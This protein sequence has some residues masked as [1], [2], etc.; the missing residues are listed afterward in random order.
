MLP[1]NSASGVMVL[2]F[3]RDGHRD[4]LFACHSKNGNHRTDSFLYW[5]SSDGFSTQRR[6]LLPSR[7]AHLLMTVDAGN[8]YDR[9]NRYE[10]VSRPF[11]A[12]AGSQL[13]EISWR[14][15]TPF[16]T[17]LD[18]Q[19]RTAASQE[20][21]ANAPWTGPNGGD[22]AFTAPGSRLAETPP[23]HRW[24][25]YKAGLVS[26]DSVNTPVLRSVTI[27]YVVQP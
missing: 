7:G 23:D 19:V 4:I 10:Y 22:T 3:N 14:G 26:P 24:V 8:I 12:G 11:D 15:E 25:Q 9:G 6:S 13:Q 1:T 2:D 17:R 21:L 27:E 18:F 5:G 16:R 20:E